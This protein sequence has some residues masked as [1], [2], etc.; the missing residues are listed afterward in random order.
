M[1]TTKFASRGY[2]GFMLV[3]LLNT[4]CSPISAEP[5]QNYRGEVGSFTNDYFGDGHDRW[6]SGSYQRSY[7]SQRNQNQWVDGIELRWRSEIVTPWTPSKQRGGDVPFS[8]ALGFGGSLHRNIGALETRVGGEILVL[9][10]LTGLEL[11]QRGVHDGLGM[12]ESYDPNRNNVEHVENGV[13]LRFDLE[14]ATTIHINPNSMI[15]PYT[16]ITFGGDQE[17]MVGADIVLGSLAR[18]EIWTRDVVTGR[19]LTPQVAQFR[20]LSLVAGWDARSVD[21]S[22]HLPEGSRVDMEPEQFR[23]RIGLQVN[24]AFLDFFIGQA[25]LTSSFVNQAEPQ[26]VGML[27]VAFAF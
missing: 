19:L 24:N 4:W 17:T 1:L 7:Y 11:V 3:L 18:A 15:R 9:G 16:A 13:D 21:A 22:I 6:R 8:T 27:S 10:E 12:E 14:I 20:S 23:T 2:L 5:T 25:W 26:R